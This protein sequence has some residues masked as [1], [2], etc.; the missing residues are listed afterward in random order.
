MVCKR[1]ALMLLAG[2]LFIPFTWAQ[3]FYWEN[4]VSLTD[5]VPRFPSAKVHAGQAVMMW[6]EF[7]ESEM[8]TERTEGYISFAYSN[9]GRSWALEPRAIGP[10]PFTGEPT[11]FASMVFDGNITVAYTTG[12]NSIRVERKPFPRLTADDG[13]LTIGSAA[14]FSMLSS[15]VTTSPSVVPRIYRNANNEFLLFVTQETQLGDQLIRGSGFGISFARSADGRE[16]TSFSPLINVEGLH[17]NY[18]P[19]HAVLNGKDYVVFQVFTTGRNA[20]N[21]LYVVSSDDGGLTWS[22]PLLI[23]EFEDSQLVSPRGVYDN[24]RPFL[25]SDGKQLYLA[26]ERKAAGTAVSSVYTGILGVNGG[27]EEPGPERV[28]RATVAARNPEIFFINDRPYLIWFD[29]RAGDDHV[30]LAW[31]QGVD[32]REWDL[33]RMTGSSVFPEAVVLEDNLY[34][35]WENRRDEKGDLFLLMP[36][37]TV[38]V[39]VIA[40]VNFVNRRPAKQDEFRVTWSIGQDSSGIAGYSYSWSREQGQEPPSGRNPMVLNDTRSRD[41]TL[42]QDGVWYFNLR[43]QDYAGNWS[44]TARVA[45]VRD[46]TPPGPP[47]MIT[48][49]TD[50]AGFL[51]ANTYSLSW[52]EPLEEDVAGYSYA[53]TYLAGKD[54]QGAIGQ[55]SIP[56]PPSRIMTA[57]REMSFTNQDNGY[58]VLSVSAIDSVGNVSAPASLFFRMDKYLPVTYITNVAAST[59][60]VGRVNL[61]VRGR[62]FTAE[63]TLETVILDRDGR[64][65]W[66]YEYPADAFTVVNDRLIRDWIIE[67]I[68]EGAYTIGLVHPKRGLYLSSTKIELESSGTVKFGDFTYQSDN[69]WKALSDKLIIVSFNS[70]AVLI[71]LIVLGAAIA[72]TS[73]HIVSVLK[74]TRQF[75][76]ETQVFLSGKRA[77]SPEDSKRIGHMKKRG[78]GLRLKF[79]LS[80]TLLVTLVVLMVSVALGQYMIRTQRRSLAAG[81][82]ER[83][84]VLLES[85]NSGAEAYLPGEFVVEL[86]LL[87]SQSQAMNDAEYVTITGAGAGDKS[88]YNYVW[89]TNNQ[90][91]IATLEA[92]RISPGNTLI[93]DEIT[94][95]AERL[96]NEIN[97]AGAGLKDI[98][99]EI[100]RLDAEL[101][102]LSQILFRR[103]NAQAQEAFDSLSVEKKR[104]ED[105]LTRRL[106]EISDVVE[107]Y[108]HFDPENL[109][110]SIQEYMFYKPI[111]YRS[112]TDNLFFRGIIRL[113]VSTDGIRQELNDAQ[114]NL[115]RI[116]IIIAAISA[117]MGVAGALILATIIIIPIRR[118]VAGVEKIRDTEDKEELYGHV[119]NTK[120]KDELSALADTI[121]EMTI[122]LVK[123]AQASKELTVGKEVQKMFL[124][125]EKNAEGKKTSIAREINKAIDLFGYYEGAKGVSGDYFDYIKLDENRYAIILCDVA[126]K[127]VPAS[128]IMVEVAT[129]F[130]NYFKTVLAQGG[131]VSLTELVYSINDLVEERGFQ[132]RF[133]ALILGLFDAR[134]G[135]FS[136]CNA[137]YKF[138]QLYDSERNAMWA[139]TLNE[140]PATGVFPNFMVE[141][142]GGFIEIHEQL[143]HNDCVF[144]FSDGIEEAQRKF[145]NTD[146]EVVA[147]NEPGLKE[148]DTHDTHMYGTTNEEF[149]IPRIQGIIDAVFNQRSY[150]LVKHHN[151]LPNE[152]LTFDFTRCSG[153]IEEAVTAMVAVEKVFRMNPDPSAGANDRISVDTKINEFLK[154]HF[155][156]YSTYF[157]SPVE[158]TTDT[159]YVQFA[160][161]KE[162]EQY[163]DLTILAF[164]RL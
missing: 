160:Y 151:P 65:P 164:R 66:D 63:G 50:A 157:H 39:P 158:G 89:A 38:P 70:T 148:G 163:D 43:A 118:L 57:G 18:L 98:T 100:G 78:I 119:I 107:S 144:L 40:P 124:P 88:S 149:S 74:E 84:R 2:S 91:F 80:I 150:S 137:G 123:A 11:P 33:S 161:L 81:L 22:S 138:V 113:G 68:D 117:V 32:Y 105:E 52:Q 110:L 34:L 139:K 135:Q 136:M 162:D 53:L 93:E 153:T 130:L 44:Q 115:I 109:D 134:K 94:A 120:T 111:V 13:R 90:E 8:G 97:A 49:E 46:T 128:L 147:C 116:T 55:A 15:I 45:M 69:Y 16:W 12:A 14:S 127:G 106:K 154:E 24:Q 121:N 143:K 17:L 1:I 25:T 129:I 112:S 58:W 87:P 75:A 36:D 95:D 42:R 48:P 146:F 83:S 142:K 122:G 61:T 67:D 82:L 103:E 19:S 4:P 37:T 152:S 35:L 62:G 60:I 114:Q 20:S 132:G 92:G 23:S 64:S 47:V 7:S 10:V 72:L 41:V 71:L 5:A 156:Q 104:F 126:G 31:K 28:N 73:V 155:V 27:F 51:P 9:D 159:E 79:S 96:K 85:L 3:D 86:G 101:A 6:Y 99:D 59:D 77:L 54:Y 108:P 131:E 133:A 29:N 76:Y 125:L 56:R 21:Q 140:A 145:R 102:R 26:W 30:I 141:M